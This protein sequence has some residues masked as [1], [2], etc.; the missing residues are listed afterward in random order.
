MRLACFHAKHATFLMTV[1]TDFDSGSD[2]SDNNSIRE[3][4]SVVDQHISADFDDE[5]SGDKLSV[6]G[7][8]SAYIFTGLIL[9]CFN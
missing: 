9:K 1:D 6:M 2:N 7:D 4:G 8:N 3:F 5:T